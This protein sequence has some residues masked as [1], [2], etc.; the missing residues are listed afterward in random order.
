LIRR[1]ALRDIRR[2]IAE[3]G[4]QRLGNT[5]ADE[6]SGLLADAVLEVASRRVLVVAAERPQL[7]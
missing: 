2:E 1:S 3:V 7:L 4:L 5:P 6:L